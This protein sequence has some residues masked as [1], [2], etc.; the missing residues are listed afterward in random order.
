[1]SLLS[2][3]WE[4]QLLKPAYSRACAPKQEKPPQREALAPQLESSLHSSEDPAQPKLKILINKNYFKI[5]KKKKNRMSE[6]DRK[7][8]KNVSEKRAVQLHANTGNI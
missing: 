1:M 6:V 3:A 7:K 8:K 5:S 2:T 4:P